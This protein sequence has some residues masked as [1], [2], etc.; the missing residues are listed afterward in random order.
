MTED[1]RISKVE[2]LNQLKKLKEAERLLSDL[3][4]EEPNNI[5][6]LSLLAEIN[7]RQDKF[8]LANKII[9]NAI[10]L[11]PDSSHLFY[12]KSRIA[13][14]QEKLNEAEKILIKPL[15]FTLTMLNTL[16]YWQILN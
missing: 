4:S 15:N 13:I 3:L 8:D 7:L 16:L 11:S 12:I 9:E 10:G 1:F 6:F 2:I 5:H 14:Q